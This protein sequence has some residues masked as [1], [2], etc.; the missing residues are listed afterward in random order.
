VFAGLAANTLLGAWWLD[1]V[2]A[3][4]NR[5]LGGGGRTPGLGREVVRLRV[6]AGCT[7]RNVPI[8]PPQPVQICRLFTPATTVGRL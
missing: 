4:G 2:V 7:S 1:G 5:G 3:L 6:P 8:R